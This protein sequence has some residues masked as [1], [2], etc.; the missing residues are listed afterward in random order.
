[1][2]LPT[3]HLKQSQTQNKCYVLNKIKIHIP[4]VQ[5]SEKTNIFHKEQCLM[6]FFQ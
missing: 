4:I 1:M 2:L 6:L 3:K 5:N